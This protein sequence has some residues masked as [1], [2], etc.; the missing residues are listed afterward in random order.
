VVRVG[1]AVAAAGVLLSL[2]AGVSRTAFAMAGDRNLPGW[3]DAVHP[4]SRVPH[5][6]EI[7]V[8]AVVTAAVLVVDLRGAI[9]FSSFT[10]LAYYAVANA[11]AWTLPSGRRWRSRT[12][13]ALGGA[14]CA[15]LAFTLPAASV[16][17]GTA[18][19][20]VGAVVWSARYPLFGSGGRS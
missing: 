20:A 7:V 18:V 13:P 5:R 12:V 8:G 15:A 4:R 1:G 11:A 6:A 2:I 17:A 14:G 10:V 19:L 3:L 16:V 9:G